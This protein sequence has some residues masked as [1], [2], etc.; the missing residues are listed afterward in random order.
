MALYD[1]QGIPMR[2]A[3]ARDIAHGAAALTQVKTL[4]QPIE[5]QKEIQV[6]NVGLLKELGFEAIHERVESFAT[7]RAKENM[8]GMSGYTRIKWEDFKRVNDELEK[9]TEHT[10]QLSLTPVKEYD[11]IPPTDV[12]TK[13]QEAVKATIFDTF[14]II[15]VKKVPDPILVGHISGTKDLFFIAEWG[16]DI[17]L[18]DFIG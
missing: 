6:G 18:K 4:A 15:S 17:S 12:L 2:E 10:M 11:G 5:P 16:E 3:D 1:M 14:S 13:M 7:M 8:A 9:K